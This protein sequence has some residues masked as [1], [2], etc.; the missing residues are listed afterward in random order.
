MG[1]IVMVSG[2]PQTFSR[3]PKTKVMGTPGSIWAALLALLLLVPFGQ[4][5]GNDRADHAEDHAD[6]A[7]DH[8]NATVVRAAAEAAADKKFLRPKPNQTA[9]EI[10]RRKHK[11]EILS[12]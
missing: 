9:E 5:T 2:H 10:A 11:I 4:S 3:Q 1:P 7:V 8:V 12:R 6:H